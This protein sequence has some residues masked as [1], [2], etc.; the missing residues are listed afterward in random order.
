MQPPLVSVELIE[1]AIL[2][3]R[4]HRVILDAE[5]AA[6]YDVELRAL[7]QAVS[8]NQERFPSDFAFQLSED[9]LESLRS[10]TVILKRGRGQH[11]K[12]LPYAFTE[13]G[14]AMLSSVLRSP[15]AVKV[16]V[17]IM[18]AFVRLRRLLQSNVELETKLA[19]L[20]TKYDA[21]FRIVFDA[22]RELMT[23]PETPEL[24]EPNKKPIGFAG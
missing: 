4:G 24:P 6:M 20:E 18:R 19:E 3:F 22:I 23:P 15:R 9:E 21:Q 13:Q 7:L 1:S 8:R 2:C 10:Q 14:V 5:L 16:N 12:Y 17:E 11:R